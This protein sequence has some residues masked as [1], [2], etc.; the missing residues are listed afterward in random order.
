MTD[1]WVCHIYEMLHKC[2]LTFKHV[3]IIQTLPF[4]NIVMSPTPLTATLAHAVQPHPLL[5]S[6]ALHLCKPHSLFQAQPHPSVPLQVSS[7]PLSKF[8]HSIIS[9]Y[10]LF[11]VVRSL[12]MFH[13]ALPTPAGWSRYTSTTSSVS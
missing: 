7:H 3:P 10:S 2:T 1:K 6:L 13:C 12:A 9:T 11:L 8:I 4:M 5:A